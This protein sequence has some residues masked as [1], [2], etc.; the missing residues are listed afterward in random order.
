MGLNKSKG[1]MFDWIT[2]T[3]N[4][5]AGRC[6]INCSYCSS[7]KLRSRY[8]ILEDKYSGPMRLEEKELNTNL[9][10]DKF[11][12]VA[13]QNDLFAS[14]VSKDDIIKV[15]DY[16]DKFDNKYLF[17]TKN[18]E[19][20]LNFVSHKVFKKAVIATTIESDIY[21]KKIVGNGNDPYD[22]M[23]AMFRLKEYG[24]ETYITVE[25][26]MKFTDI[27]LT[28]LQTCNADQINIGAD[29]GNN[30]LPEPSKGNIEWLIS[31]LELYTKVKIKDNLKRLL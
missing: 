4:P 19:R 22:R 1:N 23:K 7:N 2:H 8:K 20:L 28:L 13:A 31:E 21:H 25:P 10:K 24:F 17:Q 5:I 9:G 12:F 15:L 30:N 14:D 18:P 26:I 11:I 3:W 29:T 27:F 16:C 6:S